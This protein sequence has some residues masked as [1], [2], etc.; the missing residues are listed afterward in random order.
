MKLIN[1]FLSPI[2]LCILLTLKKHIKSTFCDPVIQKYSE[3]SVFQVAIPIFT[4]AVTSHIPPIYLTATFEKQK[5]SQSH[6]RQRASRPNI[7]LCYIVLLFNIRRQSFAYRVPHFI[8]RW[9]LLY[10]LP[11]IKTR[12]IFATVCV[13]SV[14]NTPLSYTQHII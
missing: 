9:Q 1:S 8:T 3:Q 2:N 5:F 6:L 14:S 4:S 12:A 13:V 7:C 10:L 11:K